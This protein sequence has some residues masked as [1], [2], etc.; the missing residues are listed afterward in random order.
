MTRKQVRRVMHQAGLR[1][2]YPGNRTSIPNK[3]H[4]V[5]PYLLK[6]KKIWIPNQVWTTDITYVKLKGSH[7]FLVA[8][9]DLYSRR[10][11]SRKQSNTIIPPSASRRWKRLSRYGV[12]LRFSIPTKGTSSLRPRSSRC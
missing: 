3:Q 6:G 10:V 1:A 2:I 8:I 4:P 5:Y 7:V 12:L 9:V 11:L